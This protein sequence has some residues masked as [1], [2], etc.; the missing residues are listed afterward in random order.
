MVQVENETISGQA[1]TLPN[2]V[3]IAWSMEGMPS[4]RC[5]P[6]D[7]RA[8]AAHPAH[9]RDPARGF[10]SDRQDIT[11][12]DRDAT[13]GFAAARSEWAHSVPGDFLRVAVAH[14]TA[15][16]AGGGDVRR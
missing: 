2:I 15:L 11:S 13:I 3:A 6:G 12:M 5:C 16:G 10:S 9:G 4:P 7:V 14:I 8:F 1:G